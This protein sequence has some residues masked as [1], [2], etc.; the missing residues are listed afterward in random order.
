MALGKDLVEL[1]PKELAMKD[2]LILY[3]VLLDD[4]AE[5]VLHAGTDTSYDMEDDLLLPTLSVVFAQASQHAVETMP[6]VNLSHSNE[7]ESGG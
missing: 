6:R 7:V 4:A 1:C 3:L 2:D 5:V